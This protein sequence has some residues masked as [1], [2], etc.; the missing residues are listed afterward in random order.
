MTLRK[1]F[2]LL[3]AIGL[4]GLPV[5]GCGGEEEEEGT[6]TEVSLETEDQ[7]ND[8]SGA[9]S[10][11]ASLQ[12]DLYDVIIGIETVEDAEAADGEVG[13]I[14]TEMADLIRK[15]GDDPEAAAAAQNDPQTKELEQKMQDHIQKISMKDPK[16]GLAIGQLMLRHSDKVM[17]AATE[18]LD[19][20]DM[21]R[22]LEEAGAALDDAE[23]ALEGLSGE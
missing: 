21:S 3:F 15:Y 7:G 6:D 18:V 22:A 5:T 20:D 14:F 4:L 16:V 19:S 8:A 17:K 13:E 11:M 1:I 10:S 9:A 23:K 2:S 12:K